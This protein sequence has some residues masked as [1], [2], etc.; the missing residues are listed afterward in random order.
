MSSGA[1]FFPL[2]RPVGWCCRVC[3]GLI[4]LR[5]TSLFTRVRAVMQAGGGACASTYSRE[6]THLSCDLEKL[7]HNH[8]LLPFDEN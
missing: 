2:W 8:C 3:H 1:V 5:P 4:V 6:D 7:I